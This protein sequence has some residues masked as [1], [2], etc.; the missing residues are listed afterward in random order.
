LQ[1]TFWRDKAQ[2]VDRGRHQKEALVLGECLMFLHYVVPKRNAVFCSRT[3]LV[4]DNDPR[5]GN[6]R[7]ALEVLPGLF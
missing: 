3:P 1:E 5:S 7:K 6:V 2:L 4:I